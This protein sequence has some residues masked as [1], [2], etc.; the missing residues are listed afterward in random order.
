MHHVALALY[1]GFQALNLAVSTVLE[2]ANRALGE[3]LYQVHLLSEHGGPVAS[4][5]GFAVST[6]PFGR[7]R[8][9]TV[10]VV[11]DNDVLP[12][13]PA[14]VK[15]LQRAARTSR[16]IGATC[17]GAFTLAEA[18]LLAGRRATTHWYY[19]EELRR[20][21]PD[22]GV[23]E[24]RIF[25]IDGPVWTSAG[26]S[27]CIDLALALVE[28][29]AG[30]A[31]ARGVAKSLVVY[32]RRAGGQSQF[33]ALLDLEP[34]SDRIRGALDFA[35]Q[36]LQQDLSVE[37]LANAAHLSARQFSR[38]FR[39]ETGQSPA[40]AVERLRV[41]AARLMMESGR[42]PIDVVARETGFGDPE[43]M[44]RAF[45]RAFGQPPQAIRRMARGGALQT[46]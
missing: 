28:K 33:S 12:A 41:E 34:R 8:F 2:F 14:L 30:A 35:R 11:G 5:G 1:P 10:L 9:D 23:E 25:I 42:H 27:A 26:M 18:G 21:F 39:D 13:P 43:R 4:S 37:Q 17:T 22:V 44:R 24:D 16:R 32:H 20:R 15:F 45:L 31:V 46:A 6:A 19:A 40:K 3:P 7:R 38:A 29:D 36:N